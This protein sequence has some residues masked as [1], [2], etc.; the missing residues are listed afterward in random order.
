M[1]WPNAIV[2]MFHNDTGAINAEFQCMRGDTIGCM[3]NNKHLFRCD[4][5]ANNMDL[6]LL[7]FC[8]HRNG[9]QNRE[10]APFECY[11]CAWQPFVPLC[12]KNRINCN[13]KTGKSRENKP[14]LALTQ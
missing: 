4:D 2:C 8:S 9:H 12:S 3:L 5:T 1:N 6:V 10:T 13:P 14:K 7:A 11:V